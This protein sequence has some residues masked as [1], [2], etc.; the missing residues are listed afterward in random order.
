MANLELNI[1]VVF[2]SSFWAEE[3]D[4][5]DSAATAFVEELNAM[6]EQTGGNA[7]LHDYL[8]EE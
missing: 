4:D 3:F 1:T 6:L 7:V 8:V 2:P 5:S